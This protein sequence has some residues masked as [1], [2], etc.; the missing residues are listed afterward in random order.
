MTAFRVASLGSTRTEALADRQVA[1]GA[2]VALV[3]KWSHALGTVAFSC[4]A[5]GVL[6]GLPRMF[7]CKS[8]ACLVSTR[9]RP[10]PARLLGSTWV[11]ACFAFAVVPVERPL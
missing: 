8:F 4:F 5:A 11:A 9:A 1:P 10:T 6:V 3:R 2:P 7:G